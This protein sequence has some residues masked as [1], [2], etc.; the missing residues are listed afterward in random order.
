MA[1][2]KRGPPHG[3]KKKAG[4]SG[5]GQKKGGRSPSTAVDSKGKGRDAKVGYAFDRPTP[6]FEGETVHF[7]GSEKP[8]KGGGC[9]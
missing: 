2:F 8:E 6:E 1:K 5:K 4:T 7:T 3:G 9:L